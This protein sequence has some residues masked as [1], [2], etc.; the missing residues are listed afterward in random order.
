MRVEGEFL[1][2]DYEPPEP[3][4]D[5]TLLAYKKF[6]S[7]TRVSHEVFYDPYLNPSVSAIIEPDTLGDVNRIISL[8]RNEADGS[9]TK[10]RSVLYPYRAGMSVGL[11]H[12]QRAR[13]P[14]ESPSP[15]LFMPWSN[16]WYVTIDGR[17]ILE[18]Y[19][20]EK[21]PPIP[22]PPKPP[23]SRRLKTVV[24]N[25]PRAAADAVARR[26]GYSPTHE[27]RCDDDY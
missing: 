12:G 16:V 2:R 19:G 10:L 27:C 9:R 4:Y 20:S 6:S 26:L 7:V 17:R 5:D 13:K 18:A 21:L 1:I 15:W 24:A 8:V 11:G 3:E 22:P 23:L 25:A 14:G